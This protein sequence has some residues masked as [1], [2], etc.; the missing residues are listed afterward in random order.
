MVKQ[1]HQVIQVCISYRRIG[2]CQGAVKVIQDEISLK[3]YQMKEQM[4]TR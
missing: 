3:L 2:L 4:H 1:T